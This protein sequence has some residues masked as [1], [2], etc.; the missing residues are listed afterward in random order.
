VLSCIFSLLVSNSIATEYFLSLDANEE[1]GGAVIRFFVATLYGVLF[2]DEEK[3]Y[4][5][6]AR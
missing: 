2:D 1:V 4:L 5:A 6:T 3:K